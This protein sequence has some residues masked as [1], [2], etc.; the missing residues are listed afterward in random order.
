MCGFDSLDLAFLPDRVRH[1]ILPE[2]WNY[3]VQFGQAR[4]VN[5]RGDLEMNPAHMLVHCKYYLLCCG[6]L[7]IMQNIILEFVKQ[8]D[9]RGGTS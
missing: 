6:I 1:W 7:H 5:I 8:I 4:R 9:V 2:I 3:F